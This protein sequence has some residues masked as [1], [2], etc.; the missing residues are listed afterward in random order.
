MTVKVLGSSES[1]TSPEASEA[2]FN[3]LNFAAKEG[4]HRLWC[5]REVLIRVN[6]VKVE[7]DSG[8]IFSYELSCSLTVLLRADSNAQFSIGCRTPGVHQSAFRETGSHVHHCVDRRDVK[9]RDFIESTDKL[10]V[11]IMRDEQDHECQ[12]TSCNDSLDTFGVVLIEIG[13]AL[14]KRNDHCLQVGRHEAK[15]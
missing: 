2:S 10:L 6:I 14:W 13:A 8:E 5:I 9:W 12:F 11:S 1:S 15:D 3:C 4:H 7:F